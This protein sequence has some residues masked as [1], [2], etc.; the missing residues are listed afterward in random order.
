MGRSK[1]MVWVQEKRPIALKQDKKAK[2]EEFVTNFVEKTVKLQEKLSRI[3]I[4]AGRVYV[5]KLYE[6]SPIKEEGV[7]FTRPLIDG[8][9]LEFPYLRITLYN[10]D[11]T[12]CTLDFQRYNEQ[13]M[14]I[15]KG[16]LEEC[17]AEAEES[18]WFE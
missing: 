4:R 6:P 2:L 14:S 18:E 12:D 16:T 3:V 17:L 9:Y 11:Y 1:D 5:Y 15:Y 8:K 10:I 7:V 13:W